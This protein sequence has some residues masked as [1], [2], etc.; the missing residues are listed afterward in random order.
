MSGNNIPIKI[1]AF[2]SVFLTLTV[3]GFVG[4]KYIGKDRLSNIEIFK[5]TDSVSET[6][7]EDESD[8]SY[9]FPVVIATENEYST[10]KE[11]SKSSNATTQ[12]ATEKKETTEKKTTHKATTS[13]RPSTTKVVTTRKRVTTTRRAKATTT[14]RVTTTR[15]ATTTK[16]VTTTKAVP[17]VSFIT[18]SKFPNKTT[19]YIGDTFSISGVRV[20]AH[21]SDGS[22]K[23][24]T[25]QTKY[26][27]PDMSSYGQKEVYVHYTDSLGNKESTY[28]YI[29]VDTP[30][31]YLDTTSLYLRV[32]ES[33]YLNASTSPAGK[34]VLWYT[35]SSSVVQ[36]DSSGKVTAVGAGSTGV[37]A[38]MTYNGK[39][40]YS[41]Y[42]WIEVSE[43]QTTTQVDSQIVFNGVNTSGY[44]YSVPS[45]GENGYNYPTELSMSLT[46]Y[47]EST[48]PI[49]EVHI[50]L[51]GPVLVNGN[52]IHKD[53]SIS[54]YNINSKKVYLEDYNPF[55]FDVLLEEEYLV[56]VIA[57]D[58]S[59]NSNS[60]SFYI[61]C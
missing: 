4:F 10:A 54:I 14:R 11:T 3:A 39:T 31:V 1:V 30:E 22:E 6:D 12:K 16:R 47:I 28:F 23:D 49:E 57:Y 46:G 21:F 55:K 27:P 43:S 51:S 7:F 20:T 58:S 34:A 26:S 50:I 17:Y 59:G 29:D 25:S 42:C 18:I 5:T 40:Y 9:T 2:I 38:A 41:E 45:Y 48:M 56:T 35:R 13:K 53:Q 8:I 60:A 24:V 33:Y 44:S 61:Y 19:Y 15:K 52:K 37:Y 32:G 36:V